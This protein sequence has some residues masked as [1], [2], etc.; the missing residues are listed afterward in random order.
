VETAEPVRVSDL[1]HELY[2]PLHAERIEGGGE[3]PVREWTL[4][5]SGLSPSLD[6]LYIEIGT[7]EPV[8]EID[9]K[10]NRYRVRISPTGP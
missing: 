4:A 9:K 2:A 1:P 8:A 3:S 10:N 5:S 7:A 6:H